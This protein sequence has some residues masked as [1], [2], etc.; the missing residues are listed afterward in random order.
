[1]PADPGLRLGP[2]STTIM[3]MLPGVARVEAVG[4]SGM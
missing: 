3:T 4:F 1:M 2:G